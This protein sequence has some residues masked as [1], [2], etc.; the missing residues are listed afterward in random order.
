MFINYAHRGASSYAP[1]NTLAAFY[2]GVEMGANGIETDVQ[3]TLDGFLVLRHDDTALRTARADKKISDLTLSELRSL[4]FGSF[5]SPDFVNERIVTLEDFLCY[6]GGKPLHFAIE[7]KQDGIGDEVLAMCD[8]YLARERFIITSFSIDCIL[9]LAK[10]ENPPA[11]GYLAAAFEESHIAMLLDAGVGQYC[12]HAPELDDN[13]MEYLRGKGF[14]IRAWGVSDET[15][16]LRALRL[17]VD[18]M[19]VNFPDKLNAALGQPDA[20]SRAAL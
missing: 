15:V 7:I 6:F 18:G 2:K 13:M 20:R 16:M 1:E 9:D 4:D 12:P 17:G 5:F 8:D 11:L 3:R 14:N 19:T 10:N